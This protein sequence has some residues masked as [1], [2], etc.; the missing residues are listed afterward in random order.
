MLADSDGKQYMAEA[1]G[2]HGIILM[3][4]VDSILDLIRERLLLAFYRWHGLKDVRTSFDDVCAFCRRRDAAQLQANPELFLVRLQLPSSLVHTVLGKL[5]MDA[6]Y[7]QLTYYPRPEHRSVA[8]AN[9]AS[10]IYI[11]LNFVPDVLRAENAKMREIVDKFFPDNW[12]ITFNMGMCVNLSVAWSS[13]PAA[14][15][16]LQDCMAYKNIKKQAEGYCV[17]FKSSIRDLK[18]F[19]SEVRFD[20]CFVFFFHNTLER[21]DG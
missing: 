8:L 6:I 10:L 19:S 21:D 3:Q 15:A 5:R 12:V 9:E 7:N 20:G 13:Y 1:I 2:L 4:L 17:Q 14:R 18:E 11:L 16:A